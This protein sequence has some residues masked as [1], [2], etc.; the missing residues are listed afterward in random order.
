[1]SAEMQ[2]SWLGRNFNRIVLI[3]FSVAV[4][5][6]LLAIF[7]GTSYRLEFWDRGVAF[8][9]LRYGAIIAIG[10]GLV[11][12]A[13]VIASY[14]LYKSDFI[15]RS[16]IAV[17]GVVIGALA[18]YIPYSLQQVARTVPPIHDITTDFNNPPLFEAALALRKATNAQNPSEYVREVT[19]RGGPLDVP[20]AQRGAYPDIRT[21]GLPAVSADELFQAAL[22]TA[23]DMGWT[24]IA[25][26]ESRGRIEAWDQTLW[27]GFIDDV[28]I[29]I[30]PSGTGSLID[31]RSVSRVGTSDVGKNAQRIRAYLDALNARLM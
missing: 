3:G 19:V 7:S 15:S 9:I 16:A 29:R 26:D 27:Y 1:M 23:E 2:T 4:L 5:G 14:V 20:Q 24:I 6:A 31:V 13:A 11:C 17:F 22:S 28:V 12:L 18:F 21:L 10:G 25:A 30:L 8:G